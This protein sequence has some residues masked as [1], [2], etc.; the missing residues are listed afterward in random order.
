MSR[1]VGQW[2]GEGNVQE[3]Q[4]AA[5]ETVAC[6][7]IFSSPEAGHI[8]TR[9]LCATANETREV[10]GHLTCRGGQLSG[11][12]L[13]SDQE[14]EPRLISATATETET[15]LELEGI[16]PS[17]GDALRYRLRVTFNG[18]NEMTMRITRGALTALNIR[19]GR[20]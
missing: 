1:F 8:V 18:S 9:G 17:R 6:R 12:L 3:D 11:P 16:H 7:I 2:Y 19:Y 5:L 15:I 10:S 13:A 4:D 20:E 14:P